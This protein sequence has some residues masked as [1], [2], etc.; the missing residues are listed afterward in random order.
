MPRAPSRRRLRTIAQGS[1]AIPT[2]GRKNRAFSIRRQAMTRWKAAAA[3]LLLSILVI[4][5]IAIA[6][7]L[8]WY[9]DGLHRVSGLDGIMRL[10]LLVDLT[11]GPLLT[12]IVYR[13][14]KPS[15]KF[16]LAVIALCQLAFLGYGLY[17]LGQSRP[18]FLLGQP[19]RFTLVLADEIAPEA[20]REAPRPEWRKLSWTGPVLVA[21][22]VPTDP[23]LRSSAVQAL[24]SGGA[25]IE[26]SPRWYLAYEDVAREIARSSRRIDSRHA[27]PA[28]DIHATGVPAEHLRWH[29]V[30][31]R[32]GQGRML[33][34][35]RDGRPL[36]VVASD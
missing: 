11:A 32:L 4:G 27:I 6:A 31:S 7:L 10:M 15:L 18:V 24:F 33:I 17:V 30:A 9:P 2:I 34:D 3:H 29:P 28:R 35:A 36:R 19:D 13:Q 1:L 12:L 23:L 16:D 21:T 5:G 26:H 20:L 25:G 14:G 8:V 22:R